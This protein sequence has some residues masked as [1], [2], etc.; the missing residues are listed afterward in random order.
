[1]SQL[2]DLPAEEPVQTPMM[3]QYNEMK[4]QYPDALLLFRMGDFY[5]SFNEDAI[6]VS[7]I[8]GI[9]L[10]KRSH[11]AASEMDL[12]GFPYHALDTYL[13]KLIRAGKRIAICEQLEN[14]KLTKKLV[15]RGIIEVITPGVVTDESVLE[16]RENNYLAALYL[17]TTQIG[18]ALVDISTGEFYVTE[19][20]NAYI[21]RL[22]ANFQP[23]EILIARNQYELLTPDFVSRFYTTKVDDWAFTQQDAT[24][25]LQQHFVTNSLRGLGIEHLELG[26]CAAG[27]ILAYLELTKHSSLTH[28]SH[29][30]RIEEDRYVWLDRFTL[31]HLEIFTTNSEGGRT[32]VSTVDRTKTPMGGRLLR[33]WLAMPLKELQPIQERHQIVDLFTKHLEPHYSLTAHLE[34]IGDLERIAS[35]IAMGRILPREIVRMGIALQQITPCIE[36]AKQLNDTTLNLLIT[37]LNPC[38][39]LTERIERELLPNPANL[40][41]GDVFA[42]GVSNELD[43]LR[44]LKNHTKE[45][46]DDMLQRES[47]RT[48]IQ[49]LKIGFN[50]VFGYYFEVRKTQLDNIPPHWE[51]RQTLV[52]AARFINPELKEFEKNILG[53]EERII[54][55]EDELFNQ[56]LQHLLTYVDTIQRNAEIIAQLDVLNAFAS[57]ANEKGWQRPLMDESLSIE[58][59]EVWHPVIA[60]VLPADQTYIPNTIKLDSEGEQI[61]M[62]TGPNMSGKSALL[63]QT[64]LAVLLAQAGAFVPAKSARIGLV[65]KIFTRVG[66]SDNI[67]MGESTFMVEMVEAAS[68]LNNLSERSL[69]LLD[70]IGRG[71]STYDGIS[72]AWAMAEYLHENHYGHPKT[73]FATHY[74][75]LNEM[76]KQFERIKNY[77][78]AVREVNGQVIF[79]RKL[80]AGGSEHSFGIH[81][82]RLAGM[83]LRVVQRAQVILQLLEQ[84]R[85]TK[86]TNKTL[87]QVSNT[88]DILLAPKEDPTLKILREHLGSY[89]LDQMTPLQALSELNKLIALAGLRNYEPQE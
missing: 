14:P 85:Q 61:L 73:L 49:N 39:E 83:P 35:K 76:E 74:H 68:I 79:I 2:F 26:I 19:G 38:T 52:Q 24:L 5:E 13:P 72:I 30:A 18:L 86:Q 75:E 57:L 4:S 55:I 67:S 21:D 1:M 84:N 63:R 78:V 45:K 70:E 43:E 34:S 6:E 16:R 82:A 28:I 47:L 71:T 10:T 15:K 44:N 42:E 56:L 7:K 69:I 29:I 23:H 65:D 46:L 88:T 64:A 81:V 37:R 27:A 51:Q 66:A 77:H 58:L 25:R 40:G 53:A 22:L 48:G 41:K 62:I 12:A 59:E 36:I 32:L 11:G 87:Q 31:R 20:N 9:T 54:A 89:N 33:R 17:V 50:N 80:E 60:D 3:K 8:L